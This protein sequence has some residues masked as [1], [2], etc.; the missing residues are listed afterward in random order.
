MTD[1]RQKRKAAYIDAVSMHRLSPAELKSLHCVSENV[2]DKY[3]YV[4]D[5]YP[6]FQACYEMWLYL[7]KRELAAPINL[8]RL[9]ESC[10]EK[11][12]RAAHNKK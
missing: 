6:T 4:A 7:N 2:I 10:N 9:I 8:R 3:L 1:D 12:E 11:A 5:R